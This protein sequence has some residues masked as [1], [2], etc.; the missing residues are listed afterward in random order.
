MAL[1]T[2]DAFRVG[3]ETSDNNTIKCHLELAIGIFLYPH[4]YL[5]REGSGYLSG[6]AVVP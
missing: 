4:I 2:D 3:M 5:G 6:T 1:F